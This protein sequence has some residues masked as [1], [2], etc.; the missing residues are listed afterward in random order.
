M[1][2][3]AGREAALWDQAR[4]VLSHDNL[5]WLYVS[6]VVVKVIHE[7]AHGF[8]CKTFGQRNGT[9]GAVHQMGIMFL[10]LAPVPFVDASSSWAF[11]NKWERLI[12]AAAGIIA[13]TVIASVAACVWASTSAGTLAH[14]IA[15]NLIFV[16]G[17]S[18]VLFNGNPLLRYDG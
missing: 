17:V 15:Y 4:G 12:V 10:V 8:A 14:A 16:A 13:E 11:R 1:F 18:T 5:L 2:H 7:F 6:F 9:G 3:L